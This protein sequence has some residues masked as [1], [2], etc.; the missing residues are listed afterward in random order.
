M[1]PWPDSTFAGVIPRHMVG[2]RTHPQDVA[3]DDELHDRS[4]EGRNDSKQRNRS[5]PERGRRKG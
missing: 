4:F 3:R 1:D 5:V 2:R